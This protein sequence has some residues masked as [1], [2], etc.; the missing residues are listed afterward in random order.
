MPLYLKL[1]DDV[2]GSMRERI[3]PFYETIQ[4][5]LG[6]CNLAITAAPISREKQEFEQAISL[7][8]D[9]CAVITLHLSYSPSLE[10]I[11]SLVKLNKPI[12]V[13][14]TTPTYSFDTKTSSEEIM[15][16][17]GIHGVQDMCN[18]LKRHNVH[19]H[20]VAGHYEDPTVIERV[21]DICNAAYAASIMKTSKVGLIGS[22]FTGMGDFFITPDELKETIGSEVVQFDMNEVEAYKSQ[23]A[24]DEVQAEMATDLETFALGTYDEEAHKRTAK[25]S[26]LVR[27]WVEKHN[28]SAFTMN[29]ADI[30]KRYGF[31]C[32]PFMEACKS[33]A[34]GIGYAG[35]GDVLT[36]ALCGALSKV[37][38]ETS[39]AEMFCPDWKGNTI[40][41]SH[42]GEMNSKTAKGKMKL[43]KREYRY[44]DVADPMVING[45]FKAGDA[46]LVNL[47]PMGEGNYTLILSKVEVL[48][49]DQN[50]DMQDSI[51]GWIRPNC[52]VS[53]FLENYSL[54]GG[55]HHL[56][57]VYG[58]VLSSLI[59]FGKVMN[60]TV[61]VL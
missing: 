31:E 4:N 12:I 33:M 55:T 49:V 61:E 54:A 39:F 28:L 25:M 13:L 41:L 23:I 43:T 45:C 37:Y 2:L 14:D 1:Y 35:E 16:N 20:V 5:T 59:T 10:S 15:Y 18:M 34:R 9:V 22:S 53:T 46:V 44:S 58:N 52:P 19:Y 57:M 26:L 51:H 60:F 47:A 29:F 3:D 32:V 36:A 7:F 42:M 38:P 30:D 8:D 40:F 24:F 17:H 48:D 50:T 27:K 21:V 11:D 56:V 6:D